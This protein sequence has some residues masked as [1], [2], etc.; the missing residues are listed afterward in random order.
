MLLAFLPLTPSRA[1]LMYWSIDVSETGGLPFNRK[2][3]AGNRT[4][5][6]LTSYSPLTPASFL[7]QRHSTL[8]P[9]N[10]KL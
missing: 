1:D 5:F 3:Q 10:P 2:S 7:C 9:R 4:L 6:I 8:S